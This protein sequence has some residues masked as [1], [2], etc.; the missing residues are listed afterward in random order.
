VNYWLDGNNSTY[1]QYDGDDPD[2]DDKLC[3]FIEGDENA[4][5]EET[6]CDDSLYYVCKN[7]SGYVVNMR[8]FSTNVGPVVAWFSGSAL[9]SING[10]TLRRARLILGW[11]T[12]CG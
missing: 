11:V 10:V 9:V 5:F 2:D 3:F 7:T 1:R 8:Q 4:Q 12:V 6:D